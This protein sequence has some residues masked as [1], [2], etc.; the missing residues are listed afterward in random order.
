MTWVVVL[1]AAAALFGGVAISA[2]Q[3]ASL[4]QLKH[5]PAARSSGAGGMPK[6]GWRGASPGLLRGRWAG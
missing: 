4:P 3:Q 2:S 5:S 1:M 6:G